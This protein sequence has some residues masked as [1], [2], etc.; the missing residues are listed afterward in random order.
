MIPGPPSPAAVC[1]RIRLC[2]CCACADAEIRSLNAQLD[3]AN[4]ELRD[5]KTKEWD[6]FC[7]TATMRQPRADAARRSV[8]ARDLKSTAP[9]TREDLDGPASFATTQG[10]S[11]SGGHGGGNSTTMSSKAGTMKMSDLAGLCVF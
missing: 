5:R 9:L 4:R 7:R 1:C 3:F 2:V 6:Q 11:V 8:S 10:S